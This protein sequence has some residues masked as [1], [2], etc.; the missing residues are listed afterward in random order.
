MTTQQAGMVADEIILLYDKYG[1]DDYIGE[2]VSQIE[3]MMQCAMLAEASGADEEVV[4]A[5]FF[6]DIGHFCEHIMPVENMDGYGIVNHEKLGSAYLQDNGFS[7]KICLLV[8][9]HVAAKRYLTYKYPEYLSALSKA[10]K[11]ML[12]FQGGVMNAEE[13]A[14]FEADPL[15]LQYIQLRRWDEQAKDIN[16]PLLPLEKFRSLIIKHLIN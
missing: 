10:S 9:S 2:P 13:A 15:F 4:L 8:N 14:S 12:E 11:K 5:A 6:H 16:V 7:A 1:S 3:H